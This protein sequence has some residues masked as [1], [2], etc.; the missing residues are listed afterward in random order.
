MAF[1]QT[2]QSWL[3]PRIRFRRGSIVHRQRFAQVPT[4]FLEEEGG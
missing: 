3:I 1:S 2:G 4:G